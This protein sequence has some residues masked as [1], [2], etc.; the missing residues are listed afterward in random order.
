MRRCLRQ[1]AQRAMRL[2][3]AYGQAVVTVMIPHPANTE[4]LAAAGIPPV[5]APPPDARFAQLP[6][7]MMQFGVQAQVLQHWLEEVERYRERYAACLA[8]S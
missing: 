4:R 5:D 1:A 8:G 7:L 6:S 2:S 3:A